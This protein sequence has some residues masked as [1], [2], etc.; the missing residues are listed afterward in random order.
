MLQLFS[1]LE[2]LLAIFEKHASDWSATFGGKSSA[3][4]SEQLRLSTIFQLID[5]SYLQKR[6]VGMIARMRDFKSFSDIHVLQK[7]LDCFLLSLSG[8]ALLLDLIER[9]NLKSSNLQR[10]KI[11]AT[12]WLDG[13][14][15][16]NWI[17]DQQ[18][19]FHSPT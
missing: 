17:V 9:S 15:L 10:D 1:C 18:V 13:S 19:C 3:E 5:C 6:V 2:K 8:V 7:M 12:K 16:A 4:I 14:K 11:R